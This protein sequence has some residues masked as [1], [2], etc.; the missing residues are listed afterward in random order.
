MQVVSVRE[1][2]DQLERIISYFQE[3]WGTPESNK[4]YGNAIENSIST[5]SPIPHWYVLM[6]EEKIV[7]CAGLITND[8]ISRMD[9]YPWLCAVYIEPDYRGKHYFRLLLDKSMEDAKKGH[10]DNL[11]LSTDLDGYYEQYGFSYVG[12]GYHPWGES[13]RIYSIII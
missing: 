5:S 10:F 7:G 3:K 9:L 6:D 12:T 13:S 11:Y 8:F 4:V 1:Q 2:P